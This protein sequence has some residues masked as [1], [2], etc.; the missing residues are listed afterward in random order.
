MQWKSPSPPLSTALWP[1]AAEE[2][3]QSHLRLCQ[4]Q[5]SAHWSECMSPAQGPSQSPKPTLSLMQVLGSSDRMS[6]DLSMLAPLAHCDS[7]LLSEGSG[8]GDVVI[9]VETCC[10]RC[11][12]SRKLYHLWFG[13]SVRVS[14]MTRLH[15]IVSASASALLLYGCH[16]KVSEKAELTL[17]RS[18]H[19]KRIPPLRPMCFTSL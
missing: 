8:E 2:H 4:P 9:V 5:L 7:G 15:V 16:P 6:T 3:K 13:A 12:C 1:Q 18:L 11:S 10:A 17:E 14:R 19:Q